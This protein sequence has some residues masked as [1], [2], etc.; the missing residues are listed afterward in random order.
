MSVLAQLRKLILALVALLPVL[1]V[2][3]AQNLDF[4]AATLPVEELNPH[5]PAVQGRVVNKQGDAAAAVTVVVEISD[6]RIRREIGSARARTDTT[7]RFTIDLDEYG[8]VPRLGLEFTTLSPR[9]RQKTEIVIVN[10]DELPIG[11]KLEVEAGSVARGHV[12]NEAG[13]PIEGAAI[14]AP[15]VAPVKT[16]AEGAFEIFGLYGQGATYLSVEKEG[17]TTGQL[18]VQSTEPSLIDG[19][20]VKLQPAS[21]LEGVA[22]DPMGNP[23]TA[24]T[25]YISLDEER[26]I[27]NRLDR[28]GRFRFAA[29]P[30]ELA[31]LSIILLTRDYPRAERPFTD[32]EQATR[33]VRLQAGWPLVLAGTVET[34]EGQPGAGID[35]VIGGGP[36]EAT[37]R[38]PT[39]SEGKWESSPLSTSGEFILTAIPGEPTARFE[40]GELEFFNE[41]AAGQWK[42]EVRPWPRGYE[43]D[44]EVTITDGKVR[45]ARQDSGTG[46]LPGRIIYEGE[47]DPEFREMKGTVSVE[48]TGAKGEFT[49]RAY[50]PSGSM[51]GVWD[52]RNNIGPGKARQAPSQKRVTGAPFPGRQIIALKTAEPQSITG[53]VLDLQGNPLAAG[54]VMITSWNE[55]NVL[56][57]RKAAVRAGGEF[58]LD[59]L[60]EG[61]L[62]IRAMNEEGIPVTENV[63]TRGGING[64]IL[65]AGKERVDPMDRIGGVE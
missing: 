27:S 55:T 22:V 14:S 8:D 53:K 43:S 20:Y 61:I 39:D 5:G 12:A 47:I 51:R 17:Y 4:K 15:G 37:R 3:H 35:V 24:G 57:G 64:L 46:A 50:N 29:V 52:L 41:S 10:Q 28:E 42:G 21:A 34:A 30:A 25:V 58:E 60:P 48:E 6:M 38:F 62:T 16:D 13:E 44:F 19:L 33:H 56:F 54:S 18:V 11:V 63:Y 65:H 31:D 26:Y 32:E 9:Y 49:A 40:S 1:P 59:G 2:V 23:I 45:M 36:R 7:G